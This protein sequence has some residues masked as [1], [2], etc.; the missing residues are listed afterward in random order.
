MI[1]AM[2]ARTLDMIEGPEA[3]QRFDSTLRALLTVPHSELVLREKA[4]KK[5]AAKNPN[6]RGPKPKAKPSA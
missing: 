1:E 5:K 3:Y 6:K 2:K 4:Y